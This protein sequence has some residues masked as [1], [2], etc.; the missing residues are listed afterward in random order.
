MCCR[1]VVV[2]RHVL[3]SL[4]MQQHVSVS[5]LLLVFV[6]KDMDDMR[7]PPRPPGFQHLPKKTRKRLKREGLSII[8]P[9]DLRQLMDDRDIRETK[10]TGREGPFKLSDDGIVLM[11]C[12]DGKEPVR[13][14]ILNIFTQ[15]FQI[16]YF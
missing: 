7:P 1:L 14:L 9:A 12:W 4:I 15:L 6:F 10:G 11:L 13:T 16:S 5:K 2:F 3:Q 8:Q